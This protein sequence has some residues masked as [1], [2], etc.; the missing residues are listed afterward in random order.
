MQI[1]TREIHNERVDAMQVAPAADRNRQSGDLGT[2]NVSLQT[3]YDCLIVLPPER[4]QGGSTQ[5]V[6]EQSNA[7]YLTYQHDLAHGQ[8]HD[9]V[10]I[11]GQDNPYANPCDQYATSSTHDYLA[12]DINNLPNAWWPP[13]PEHSLLSS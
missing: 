2:G 9:Y 4:I 7:Q 1:G 12:A 5:Y 13:V 8:S 3:Q 10:G 6:P 11:L